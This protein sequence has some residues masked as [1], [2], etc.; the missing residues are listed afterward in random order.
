[1]FIG[2]IYAT[3]EMVQSSLQFLLT[4][5]MEDP[6][7][8]QVVSSLAVDHSV[9]TAVEPAAKARADS[10]RPTGVRMGS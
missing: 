9:L 2:L 1:L 6:A 3:Q 7:D 5:H 8:F 4:G 10:D